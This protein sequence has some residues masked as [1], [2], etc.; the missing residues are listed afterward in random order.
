[1]EAAAI[2]AD[3]SAAIS[4]PGM[5]S[6]ILYSVLGVFMFSGRIQHL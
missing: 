5:S 2:A 6:W 3:V 1:M 4:V